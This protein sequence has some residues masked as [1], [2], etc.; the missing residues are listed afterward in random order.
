MTGWSYLPHTEQDRREMLSAIGVPSVEAL[1]GDI[2]AEVRLK[3]P[4]RLPA[5]LSEMELKEHFQTLAMKD[6]DFEQ[7]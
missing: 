4:L 5:P 6:R 1:F 7:T 3:R 2:P